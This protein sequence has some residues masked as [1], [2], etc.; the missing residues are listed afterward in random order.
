MY[1]NTRLSTSAGSRSSGTWTAPA[2]GE[3]HALSVGTPHG[4]R[5]DA[6][7]HVQPRTTGA[8][9]L[10]HADEFVSGRE[11]RLRPPGDICAGPEL[12]IG[13]R[14]AGRENP[15]ADLALTRPGDIVL[16]HLEDLWS[17]AVIDDDALDRLVSVC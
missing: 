1:V 6:V 9:L 2:S 14:Y 8:E 16:D 12:G 15:D 4:Q 3:A 17:S 11:W 5:A 10:D 13:E 7:S